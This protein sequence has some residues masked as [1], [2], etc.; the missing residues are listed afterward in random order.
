MQ[1]TWKCTA[2]GYLHTGES[3]PELCP[4]CAAPAELFIEERAPEQKLPPVIDTLDYLAA[5]QRKDDDVE[6]RF[7]RLQR[8]ATTGETEISAMGTHRHAVTWDDILLCGAQLDRLPL[9][10]DEDVSTRTTIG[11][12]ADQPLE[13]Q[14]P[15][16]VSHMSFG[17]LS[18]EAKISLARGSAAVGTAIGSG[19]GGM[20]KEEREHAKHYIYE[21]GT[22]RFSHVESSIRAADA[23]EIKIGQAAKPGLGGHLPA[24][25]VTDEI[26]AI[27]GLAV[28][29]DSISPSRQPD[30]NSRADL[31]R[32]VDE[33]RELTG[34]KPIG[35]K[36]AA[37]RLEQDLDFA[38]AAGPDF[39]T[40]DCRG[41]GTGAAPTV[42]KDNV[43]LH[44]I[45]ALRRARR[46]LDE[47][48]SAVTLCITGGFRDSSDIA[49]ALALGADAVA[50]AT[51][52]MMA[53]GC[54]Q[55][56]ICQTGR[57]P[58]GI[59]TQDPALRA[60]LVIDKSVERFVRFYRGTTREL[61][62]LTRLA[63]RRSV[64]DLDLSD[65]FTTSLEVAHF[66]DIAHA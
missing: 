3:V 44:A 65:L 37:G 15:F 48:R 35:I 26:A 53:I 25:K 17:A 11:K 24:D 18:K 30:I 8:L 59:A 47:R 61:A 45:F 29:E 41:G 33:L 32:K 64:H 62:T 56:R 2:C 50:L 14:I 66:T 5:W 21:L 31:R 46:F 57:C 1:K 38:L 10:K 55:Y 28:G 39:V 4:V 36:F 60:R 27:R 23:V 40:I 54:Q 51:A 13:L 34:G 7:A 49:K 20:L 58:V 6:P 12:C 42:V 19:E 63:G 52:S 16:Y 43:C 9:E 22:A